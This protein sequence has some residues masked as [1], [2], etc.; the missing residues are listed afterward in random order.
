MYNCTT[1]YLVTHCYIVAYFRIII[2][3][4]LNN[5][6]NNLISNYLL[7]KH[8]KLSELQLYISINENLKI[9]NLKSVRSR[10]WR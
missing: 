8:Q 4:I 1:V 9:N 5:N 2:I 3:F 6:I 7:K 10:H